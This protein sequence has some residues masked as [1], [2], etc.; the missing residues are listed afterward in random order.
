MAHTGEPLSF[1]DMILTLH[2]FWSA[3]GC[4]ILQP[5]DMRMGAGTCLH[6]VSVW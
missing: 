4:L 6:V 1:Q 3:Q 2:R 5:Y